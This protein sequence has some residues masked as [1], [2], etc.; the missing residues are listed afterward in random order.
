[1]CVCVSV[2][3]GWCQNH[4][5]LRLSRCTTAAAPHVCVCV[6]VCAG[7]GVLLVEALLEED[8]SVCVCV[9]VC[10][11]AGG[12]VLLVEALLEEDNSVCVCVCVCVCRWRS[13]AGGGSA[14]GG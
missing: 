7:G 2:S 5:S 6:C 9:C 1:M 4:S 12:G 14:G 10:V 11:C 8:N 13:A 3:L